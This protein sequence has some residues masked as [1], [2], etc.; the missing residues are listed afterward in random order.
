[1]S[2]FCSTWGID[3]TK[4]VVVYDD[5]HGG[6]AARLWFM[7]RW[8]GHENVAVL[9]GGWKAWMNAN[10]PTNSDIPEAQNTNFMQ[11]PTATYCVLQKI[12]KRISK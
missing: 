10:L 8:L 7:L 1:M 6:M 9:N 3:G 4:Q 2:K 12:F 5:S 11:I